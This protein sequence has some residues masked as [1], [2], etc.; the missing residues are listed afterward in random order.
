[1]I[2]GHVM[3]DSMIRNSALTPRGSEDVANAV[4]D[5]ADAVMLSGRKCDGKT[6][7][8]AKIMSETIS[9]RGDPP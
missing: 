5:H 3:L 6:V 9:V 1:M 2:A 4:I 7:G 8:A